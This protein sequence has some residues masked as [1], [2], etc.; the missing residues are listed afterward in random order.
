MANGELVPAGIFH[1]DAFPFSTDNPSGVPGDTKIEPSVV[2]AIV[3]HVVSSVSG[4]DR[5]GNTGGILR[6]VVDT[7]RSPAATRAM[8]VGVEAGLKEAIVDLDVV[9][10]YGHRIPSVVQEI[11]EIVAQELFDQIGLVAKEINVGVVGIEFPGN[12]PSR[13]V[14]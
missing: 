6:A 14:L 2:A 11:R 3:G 4:V 7:V 1:P 10:V 13:G 9:M 12:A 8:G 5:L